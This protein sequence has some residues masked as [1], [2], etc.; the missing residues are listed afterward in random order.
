MVF[1]DHVDLEPLIYVE[2]VDVDILQGFIVLFQSLEK[3]GLTVEE[4]PRDDGVG[5]V[6]DH[7]AP[8]RHIRAPMRGAEEDDSVGRDEYGSIVLMISVL[9]VVGV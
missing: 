2:K 1:V 6:L 5:H 7:L 9:D 3:Y 4:L 8:F